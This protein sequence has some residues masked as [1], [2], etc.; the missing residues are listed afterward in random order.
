MTNFERYKTEI[1]DYT[2]NDRNFAVLNGR[3]APC[4]ERNCNDCEL[5]PDCSTPGI[6][7]WLYKGAE[8]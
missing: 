7:L 4:T 6:V 5:G 1:L 8:E 2:I 3:P